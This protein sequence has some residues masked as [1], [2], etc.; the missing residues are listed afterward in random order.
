MKNKYII[1][2]I[3]MIAVFTCIQTLTAQEKPEL[4]KIS[5]VYSDHSPPDVG[6]IKFFKEEYLPKI[7]KE[8][9][10]A[11]YELDVTFH[12]EESLYKLSQ[13]V[14]ACEAGI[15]DITLFSI[16]Y[17]TERFPLHEVLVMPLL[18]FDEYSATRAWFEL[19]ETI[20]EF[21]AEFSE[22]KELIHF[23]ALP[24]IFNMNKDVRV[25]KDFK[26]LKVQGAAMVGDMFRSIGAIPVLQSPQDWRQS[27]QRNLIDGVALGI[28]GIPIFDLQDVVKYHIFPTGD[29]IELVGTSFIMNRKKF[30]KLPPE[31]QKVLED[32]VMWASMRMTKMEVDNIEGYSKICKDAGNTFIY[33]TEKEMDKWYKVF[34]PLQK[35]WIKK[36]ERNGLP[37]QKVFDEA[38]RLA[39][40][41]KNKK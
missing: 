4:K 28:A 26:G 25:P 6:G 27:L 8:L 22:F 5:L 14:Q 18:G 15:I 38:K 30:E 21:G 34:R 20:P 39:K 3:A 40:K 41:Y 10:K 7:Q 32:N 9:A 29:S 11:G 23:M 16:G 1:I 13:Q 33:L 19:Q 31:V 12:H 36:M 24:S 2:T 35:E 37:G 17:E